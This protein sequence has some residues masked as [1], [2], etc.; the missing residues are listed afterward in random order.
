MYTDLYIFRSVIFFMWRHG[1]DT[2]IP[3][4]QPVGQAAFTPDRRR[5]AL[6]YW[7]SKGPKPEKDSESTEWLWI[8]LAMGHIHI[9]IY[10]HTYAYILGEPLC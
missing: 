10:T 2:Q 3:P 6:R 8:L 9:Y 4:V 1:R 7:Q 5:V